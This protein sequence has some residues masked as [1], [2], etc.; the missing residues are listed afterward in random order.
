VAYSIDFDS[1]SAWATGFIGNVKVGNVTPSAV[2]GWTLTFEANFEITGIWNAQIV[3]KV[4]NLYT[5]KNAAWNATI[6]ANGKVDF[7]FQAA[8]AGPVVEP[9]T[10]VV[11]GETV[12][13]SD[14]PVPTL[15]TISVSDVSI[16]EGNA[17]SGN[18]NFTVALS[19][20]SDKPVTVS[21]TTEAGS[22]TP[23]SDFTAKT[24]SV[25]FAPGETSK[26]VSV[27]VLG[28]TGGESNETFKLKLSSPTNATILDGEG[29]ATI[30]NDDA[31]PPTPPTISVS[32][33]SLNEGNA[34]TT[35]ASFAISLS[36]AHTQTV[37]VTYA[38]E[39][40]TATTGSDFTAKTATVTFAP[41]ETKKTVS[42]PVLGD[43]T[44]ESNETFKLKLTS[45]VNA[46]ILDGEGVATIVNDDSTGLPRI[47]VADL[48]LSEGNS[49]TKTALVVVK[50][51]APS[52][53][54]VTMSYVTSNGSAASGSDFVAANGT[55][56]FAPGETSK[57]VPITINGDTLVEG[58]ENFQFTV[59]SPTN[60]TILDGQGTV[61]ISND[62]ALP[63]LNVSDVTISEGNSG[64]KMATFTVSLASAYGATVTAKYG[65][66]AGTASVGSDFVAQSGSLSFAPG[67]T[68]KTVSVVVN[69]DTA[70][71]ANETFKLKLSSPSNAVI[72]DGEGVATIT[73][74]DTAVVPQIRVGD[75]TATEPTGGNGGGYLST[76]GNQI[77]DAS[78]E[79]VQ[80]AGIN[81]FGA[82]TS[83]FSPD[84]LFTRN[85]KD[86]MDQ[87]LE[88]GFN[89]IR[90]PFSTQALDAGSM[91][92]DI[93]YGI[94]PDLA[95]KNALQVM[96][97][98]VAYADEIGIKIILDHHRSSAGDSASSNGLWYDNTYSE[99]RWIS[100]WKMLAARYADN[101]S[102]IG[103]DLHNEPHGSATW[104]GGGANDWAAAAERAGNAVHDVNSNW[105]IFV[106]GIES[107]QGNYY[108]W[109]GNLMG[110]RDRPI[111]L[112]TP[113][114]VVYSAHDYPESVYAQ[115]WFND[116]NYPNNLTSVF[117]KYWGYIYKENIAPVYIGEFGSKLQSAKDIAWFNEITAYLSGD[118]NTDGVKDIPAGNEGISWTYWS[119]N[120]NSGDTGGILKGD[121]S[122]VETNKITK[123]QPIMYDFGDSNGGVAYAEF[124]VTLS[125]AATGTVTVDYLTQAG[126]AGTSDFGATAGTLT[127]LAGETSKIVKVPILAD[128]LTES[129]ESFGL[130]LSKP[131]G[132]TIADAS[133]TGVIY[134]ANGAPLAKF[135]AAGLTSFEEPEVAT[136]EAVAEV[137]PALPPD[138]TPAVKEAGLTPAVTVTSDWGS[139]FTAAVAVANTGA[140]LVDDWTLTLHSDIEITNIWNAE[141]VSHAED[142]YVIR[143]A[144]WND[145]VAP[146][147]EVS[148]GFQAT[149]GHSGPVQFDWTI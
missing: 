2:N 131:V 120:P 77:V 49:G 79:T 25:T 41:G 40:G 38:T 60:A 135:A 100:D 146:G 63:V 72:G 83:R 35:N 125:Q 105:L 124:V 20:P 62:D 19:K 43:T 70:V 148:F 82:E 14:A 57:T 74:D 147:Q 47:S 55:I 28:D 45:P 108:W 1:S 117:D 7:G 50:L 29:V 149:P 76:R 18:A 112:E 97:A 103:A 9:A 36:K 44:V 73:N 54:A 64:T 119:W 143:G 104:G 94:N 58:N 65:T 12:V 99:A 92:N 67:Q 17:G 142:V 69:G 126:S 133:A 61:T 95:G 145:M 86:M 91:P 130:V 98:I 121:W 123:L 16:A 66:E 90:L 116:G 81:W 51:S 22:A 118:L 56:T 48:T 132:A 31:A 21:Y 115:P 106:E 96:D 85:Y 46:T 24:G 88:L 114:K 140:S 113:N 89:T 52:S 42:I 101:D 75:T 137:S 68:S 122:S 127:F 139:G 59:S 138:E 84:G 30:V 71:E 8:K 4:G 32:D 10:I 11:N 26:Q 34:G 37:T 78:G 110:V 3:S 128:A 102:V 136:S 33:V 144:A 13:N 39:A 129:N 87:M 111:V 80:I 15:P 141:I 6:P 23:G 27:A 134:D 5:I 107:Y 109:G 93:N 53:Q